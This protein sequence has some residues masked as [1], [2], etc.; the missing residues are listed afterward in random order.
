VA[1][2]VRNLAQR[3]ASA[4]KEIK[5]LIGESVEKVKTDASLVNQS[6]QSLDEIV[7]SVKQVG[8][9]ISE[10]AAASRE[11]MDGIELVN[12]SVT[13]LDESTQQNAAL[14]EQTSAASQN[15]VQQIN[16]MAGLMEFFSVR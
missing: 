16:Q 11:Q 5:A 8:D 1:T 4:A 10:I 14:A 12:R 6:G 3:S 7:A 13:K 2:E 9:L 15:T